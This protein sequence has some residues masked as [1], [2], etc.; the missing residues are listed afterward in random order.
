MNSEFGNK[1]FPHV[2]LLFTYALLITGENR[3][4]E[5]ILSQTF[6]NAFWFWKH[7]SEET[8]IQTWLIRIVINIFRSLP[9]DDESGDALIIDN[10]TVDLSSIIALDIDRKF[11]YQKDKLLRQIISSLPLNLKEIIIFID[12][13][14]FSY[15]RTADLIEVPE[16]VIKRRLF[17]ARK[18]ILFRWLRHNSTDKL[19][20]KNVQISLQDKLVVISSVDDQ[21]SEVINDG[22]KNLIKQEIDAQNILKNT[23]TKNISIQ[24]VR[25]AL[26][27]KLVKKYAPQLTDKINNIASSEKKGMVKFVTIAMIIIV[28][29]LIILFRPTSE[30][31]GEFA[32]GQVGKDNILVMLKNNFAMFLDSR[33]DSGVVSSDEIIKGNFLSTDGYQE[34]TNPPGFSGWKIKSQFLSSFGEVKLT[35]FIYENEIGADMYLLDIPLTLVEEKKILKLT[36]ELMNYLDKNN[37]Y[38]LRNG[39]TIYL[40]KKTEGQ[41]LGIALENPKREIIIEIC[42]NN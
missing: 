5:K 40:L 16:D 1:T 26:K 37:C 11:D 38:S 33:N 35:N 42:R 22:R 30:N 36:P 9:I 21:N 18:I 8:D 13:L 34:K 20:A 15:E 14:K 10:K 41:I 4:A 28:S 2:D 24:P 6:A 17:D 27:I 3:N 12:I 29:I 25:Q 19:T 32:L 23:I 31:P 39:A 7:L